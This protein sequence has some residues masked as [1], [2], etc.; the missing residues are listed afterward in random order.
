MNHYECVIVIGRRSTKYH[1]W[2]YTRRTPAVLVD[3]RNG[4]RARSYMRQHHLQKHIMH[5]EEVKHIQA[6]KVTTAYV[7]E[8]TNQKR[9]L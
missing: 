5:G 7:M 4:A 6:R 3:A 2:E 8:K 1:P 9:L